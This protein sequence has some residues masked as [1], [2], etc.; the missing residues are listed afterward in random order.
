MNTLNLPDV[1]INLIGEF[2]AMTMETKKYKV[3]NEM[4]ITKMKFKCSLCQRLKNRNQIINNKCKEDCLR[5]LR[6]TKSYKKMF[7]KFKIEYW[8]FRKLIRKNYY[9][10]F[11]D[12]EDSDTDSDCSS[13]SESDTSE[14]ESDSD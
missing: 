3:K 11:I 8:P 10:Y 9:N 4:K 13:E 14:S 7:V 1:L 6:E 2:S 5:K 12:E